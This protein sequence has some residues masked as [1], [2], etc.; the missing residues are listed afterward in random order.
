MKR[1]NN[2][3]FLYTGL[4]LLFIAFTFRWIGVEGTLFWVLFAMAI[5]LKTV[6]LVNIFRMKGF[7][8]K[9]W[10][11]LILTGV[12]LIFISLL[13]KTVFPIP[14]VRNILFYGAIVFKVTGLVL[15]LVQKK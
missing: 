14:W 1:I 12:V 2:T 13:F 3:V 9:V 11:Y 10:L 4:F 7:Q 6:F 15:M 8:P 5:L